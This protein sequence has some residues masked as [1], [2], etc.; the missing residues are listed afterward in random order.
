MST[1]NIGDRVKVVGSA[2]YHDGTRSEGD[3]SD[4][5][6]VGTVV[7]VHEITEDC[8]DCADNVSVQVDPDTLPE[9]ARDPLMEMF[10][11][12]DAYRMHYADDALALLS[13]IEA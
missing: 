8:P 9:D 12:P 3:G 7:G 4:L 1:F 13:D 5:G 6:A 11:G 2:Y 10:Y